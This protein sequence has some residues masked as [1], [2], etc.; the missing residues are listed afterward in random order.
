MAK[1]RK[2]MTEQG[3]FFSNAFVSTPICCPSCSS[4]LTGNY[5]HNHSALN[6]SIA[7]NCAA[8]DDWQSVPEKRTYATYIKEAGYRTGYFG[9]Y[10]NQY[11]FNKT[12]GPGHIPPG[13][14]DWMGLIGISKYYD[15]LVS[16][17]GV[18]EKHGND[19][20]ADYFT[21]LIANR[22]VEFIQNA[23][24]LHPDD[25]F[26]LV[27]ATPAPHGPFTPA[28][29]YAD[30]YAGMHSP[31]TPNWNHHSKD[32]HWVVK[33]QAIM[34]DQR[35]NASDTIFCNRWGTL[36]SVNDL[37][38]RVFDALNQT[39][40][41]ENTYILYSSDHGFQMGQFCIPG[42]KREPYEHDIRIPMLLRGPGI[43]ANETRHEIVLN[44]D[45]APSLIAMSGGEPPASMD[46]RSFFEIARGGKVEPSEW[47]T[48]FLVDY[49]GE[50]KPQC[51]CV[52]CPIPP[53]DKF[54]EIDCS[55]NTYVC[56]R[57]LEGGADGR[58]SIY[59]EFTDTNF[60]EYYNL[61][62]DPWQL[63]NIIGSA[64]AGEVDKLKTRLDYLRKCQGE[65]CRK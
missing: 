61:K 3:V 50:G 20:H 55:N 12:G 41:L 15:Y 42:D 11:G 30:T 62:K 13:W 25:P 34:D 59:C 17:N 2:L 39:G 53:P 9:K 10:L 21:D 35:I 48:D 63:T 7:G 56:L 37:V 40:K 49:H 24:K 29:Q 36:R 32:K 60:Y 16:F 47:R 43:P 28:P 26:L 33:E 65:S 51:G 4:Y 18:V 8:T 58:D 5:I 22:S 23:T 31:R 14:D 57:T 52:T 6:N 54:H 19:Y 27:A 1:T 44:I 45:V 64:D 38:G 46:G